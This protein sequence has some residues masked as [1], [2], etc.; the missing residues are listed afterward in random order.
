M[1][2]AIGAVLLGM[3]TV[4]IF[5]GLPNKAGESPKF[6]RFEAAMMLYPPVVLVFIAVGVAALISGYFGLH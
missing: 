3:A 6:L 1:N 4:L 2:L 5:F